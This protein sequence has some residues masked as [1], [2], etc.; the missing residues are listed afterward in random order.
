MTTLSHVD[1]AFANAVAIEAVN[2]PIMDASQTPGYGGFQKNFVKVIR[3]MYKI[4]CQQLL[5][6]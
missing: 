6:F 5:T 3:A 1:P 4:N 2:E